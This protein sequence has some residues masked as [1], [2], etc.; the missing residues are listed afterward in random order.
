MRFVLV[1]GALVLACLAL[2]V[3]NS[4]EAPTE[5]SIRDV[6]APLAPHSAA[7]N[8]RSPVQPLAEPSGA[9]ASVATQPTSLVLSLRS[10][11]T[12]LSGLAVLLDGQGEAR[13]LTLRDELLVPGLSAGHYQLRIA[14]RWW[15]A[16]PQEVDL[17]D[18]VGEHRMELFAQALGPWKGRVLAAYG[19]AS[20]ARVR[21]RWLVRGEL[22]DMGY[23]AELGQ[24]EIAL[25]EG[26]FQIACGGYVARQS[27]LSI[28]AVGFE[29]FTSPWIDYDGSHGVDLGDI[30]LLPVWLRG[31]RLRGRVVA[32]ESGAGIPEVRVC[33]IDP[34]ASFEQLWVQR[35]EVQGAA[36]LAEFDVMTDEQGQFELELSLPQRLRLAAYLPKRGLSVSEPME[37]S[38][39]Q[40]VLRMPRPARPSQA[41]C[42]V[43]APTAAGIAGPGP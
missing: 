20:P 17:N 37:S 41:R 14:E 21:L 29:P 10:A 30:V 13:K 33:A 7:W 34:D 1:F 3:P 36:V 28:E 39:E 31:E 16:E 19:C 26:R 35:G 32:D 27:Q 6:S 25:D 43:K 15:T 11:T 38:A 18:S 40:V 12:P 5:G 9:R 8:P 4:F 23:R 42:S 22:G 24:A 2:M